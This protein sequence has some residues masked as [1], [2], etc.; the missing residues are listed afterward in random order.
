[1]YYHY[2][3]GHDGGDEPREMG[4][5]ESI[6]SFVF[7]DGDPNEGYEEE[8]WGTIAQVIRQN[9]GVVTAEQ[10]APYL[11]APAD[12][13]PT[14]SSEGPSASDENFVLPALL[15]FDGTPEVDDSGNLLY[16]F[17]DLQK[18]ASTR[19]NSFAEQP[20]YPLENRWPFSIAPP[21]NK[22]LAGLLG[23]A[24]FIG[25]IML[26]G[27]LK[28]PSSGGALPLVRVLMP[29]LKAYAVAFFAIPLLRFLEIT[30][31]NIKVD[32]R[33]QARLRAAELLS[34]S[35]SPELRQKLA[36]ARQ[37]ATRQ[38]VVGRDSSIV[39]DTSRPESE[40]ELDGFDRR[41]NQR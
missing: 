14:G 40:N 23:I 36:S 15:R 34:S 25:V 38:E 31:R 7:G 29:Y 28:S 30:R 32:R 33:N 37:A 22:F 2:Y 11:D 1:M 17:P 39:Y 13:Q 9:G 41:L 24:N 4:F 21:G 5:L 20:D 18:T 3:Y 27:M 16:R 8:R 26:D 35:E 19:S 10:L 12:W 6:F